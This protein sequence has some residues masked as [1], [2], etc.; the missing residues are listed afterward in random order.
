M[1]DQSIINIKNRTMKLKYIW[2]LSL[3]VGLTACEQGKYDND[4]DVPIEVVSGDADF[5]NMVSFGASF[6]A[7]VSDAT[8]F[9][10][11]QENSFPNIMAQQ[12]ALAGG[13]DFIQP[14][15]NDNIGGLLFGGNVIVGPRLYFDGSGPATLDG[16]PTTETTNVISGPFN[17]MG[18]PSAKS[19]HFLAPG[20]GNLAGVPLGLANP[21]FARMASNPNATILED[22]LAKNASFLVI[23][24]VGGNDVLSYA[25]SGGTGVDQTG[26]F[27]PTTY[28][29]DDITDPNVFAQATSGIVGALTAGGAKGVIA[30]IPY[31][32]NLPYFTTVP[33]NP[34]DPNDPDSNF[35]AL[36]PL[37]NDLYGQLNA[38]YAFLGVPERSV[39][40][41]ETEVS[42]VVIEDKSLANIGPQLT[43]VL[44]G[45]GVDPLTATLFGAQFGQS[46]QA[47]ERD[48]LTLP[49][50]NYIGNLNEEYFGFLT[51]QGVPPADAGQLS[52][53]GITY[54]LGDQWVL[55]PDEITS[56]ETATDAYNATI[57]ALA[58]QAGLGL[59]DAKSILEQLANGG[60]ASDGFLLRSDYVFGGTF[61]MD[62]LH[63][64][65]RGSAMLAN[66]F[67]KV[68]D[69]NF[70]SN[71]QEANA[72][73]DVGDYPAF[74]SENLR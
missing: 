60:I 3:L 34:L 19:F 7:G 32:T 64:S 66:E 24:D 50:L 52:V 5:T 54:P 45:G 59:V 61:S 49:N 6:V 16:T 4:V 63:L 9:I 43:Q 53:N 47:N 2:M 55:I 40:F 69:E 65:A 39:V 71:F 41:S 58:G 68:I 8:V 56:I 62:G 72:L 17:N 44:I 35:G 37:L 46:R 15:V 28:G 29:P 31:V 70:N 26:N 33:F 10:A 20:Y 23:S 42:P 67:L 14:M 57:T 30:N 22:A 48:L 13:G 73:V 51:S 36:V 25:I 21:Y 74:Y 11:S 18:V 12:M 1:G 27:D 38:A